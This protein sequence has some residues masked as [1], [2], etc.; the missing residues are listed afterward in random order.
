MSDAGVW[1]LLWVLTGSPT[2][3]SGSQEFFGKEK[4]E[5]ARTAMAQLDPTRFRGVCVH[6]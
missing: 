3:A 2:S 4:C 5:A 6:K 1:V